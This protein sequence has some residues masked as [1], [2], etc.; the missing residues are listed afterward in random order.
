MGIS[1]ASMAD[2]RKA[3]QKRRQG[4]PEKP[5]KEEYAVG[6]HLRFNVPVK[7][8]KL[9]GM[10]VQYFKANK[11]VDAMLESKWAKQ[12]EPLFTTRPG[13]VDYCNQLLEKGL[14]HRAARVEKRK[15]RDKKKKKKEGEAEDSP[16]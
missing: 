9:M 2:R 6:K 3:K 8:G 1:Q 11:A 10:T 13:C 12:K 5:T 7:E 16:M 15:D 14:F 4:E